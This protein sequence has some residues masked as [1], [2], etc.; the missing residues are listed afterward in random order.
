MHAR[1]R[2]PVQAYMHACLHTY[3]HTHTHTHMHYITLHDICVLQG[4]FEWNCLT[5]PLHEFIFIFILPPL[6][7]CSD[8]V[9]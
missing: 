7:Q 4:M 6:I 9:G 8:Y 1:L 2:T 3:M 5:S